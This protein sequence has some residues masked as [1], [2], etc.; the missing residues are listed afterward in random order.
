MEEGLFLTKTKT[1]PAGDAGRVTL[2]A[3]CDCDSHWVSG[4]IKDLRGT[5]Y[6][7]QHER[8]DLQTV[9]YTKN[10]KGAHGTTP[11]GLLFSCAKTTLAMQMPRSLRNV[12]TRW[13]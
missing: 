13:V 7:S 6:S 5:F 8:N 3:C 9:V 1:R 2:F 12:V 11:L 4:F 10:K